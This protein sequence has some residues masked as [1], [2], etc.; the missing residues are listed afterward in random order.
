MKSNE[1]K[2]LAMSTAAPLSLFGSRPSITKRYIGRFAPSPSGNLH[3]GSLVTALASFLIARQ[4]NGKWLL[5]I[6]D[7]DHHRCRAGTDVL[8]M[9]TLIEHG[10]D[11]DD[12]V[13]YQSQRIPI[14]DNVLRWFFE[15]G[16]AFYCECTR[17]QIKA[18]GE[19][20]T[21][22]HTKV[23]RPYQL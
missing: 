13:L 11:W 4:N 16:L 20:Y 14:Y 12:E 15:Q 9:E 22:V 23:P 18:K 1:Y 8:I 10:L 2:T 7:I 3:F 19:F 21:S 6:D 17:K 5:R